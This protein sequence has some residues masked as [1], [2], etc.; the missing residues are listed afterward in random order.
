[1][2]KRYL[3]DT[4]ICSYLIRENPLSLLEKFK[5][6]QR[7]IYVSSITVA[8]MLFGAAKKGSE[9]LRTQIMRFMSLVQM[10][11]WDFDAADSYAF[12]R[13]NLE[14]IGLPVD[15]MDMMIAA[16]ALSK[17]FVLVSNN[18]RHFEKINGLDFETWL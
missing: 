16:C 7:E 6:H 1:M 5:E 17:G 15:N 11:D 2:T 10:V 12:I 14:R 3:L 9:K 13:N 4:D 8:E 18:V